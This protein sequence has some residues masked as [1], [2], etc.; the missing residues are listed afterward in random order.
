MS[1]YI[2]TFHAE[3]E[4]HFLTHAEV[5]ANR[6][7]RVGDRVRIPSGREV[8]RVG[9]RLTIASQMPAADLLIRTPE[10]FQAAQALAVACGLKRIHGSASNALRYAMATMLLQS[11]GYGGVE[12]G[13]EVKMWDGAFVGQVIEKRQ[14]QVGTRYP[15]CGSGEDYESGG[16]SPR[17]TIVLVKVAGFG[18]AFSGDTEPAI[19]PEPAINQESP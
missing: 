9:Y 6:L 10:G 4:R 13:V 12:R 5:P 11:K 18:W 8:E 14:A 19:E 1:G 3:A 16:L 15:G 2:L 7:V 17:K